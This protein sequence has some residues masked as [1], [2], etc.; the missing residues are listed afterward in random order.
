MELR[1]INSV[2]NKQVEKIE[3]LNEVKNK[4]IN[5][6]KYEESNL[7]EGKILYDV[8]E[9]VVLLESAFL[10]TILDEYDFHYNDEDYVEGDI[11]MEGLIK[12]FELSELNLRYVNKKYSDCG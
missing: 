10:V 3:L 7:N 11:F 12:E 9:M 5:Y 6:L 1:R 4:F 8:N 2:K